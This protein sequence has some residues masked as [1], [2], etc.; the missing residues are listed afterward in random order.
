MSLF[1][2]V[3]T[4][5][6]VDPERQSIRLLLGLGLPIEKL[7]DFS[8]FIKIVKKLTEKLHGLL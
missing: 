8:K 3:H 4:L 2:D 6:K 5:C 7:S 1:G